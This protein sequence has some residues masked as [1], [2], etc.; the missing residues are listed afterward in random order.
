[1]LPLAAEECTENHRGPDKNTFTRT[2]S[3]LEPKFPSIPICSHPDLWAPTI[4]PSLPAATPFTESS[5]EDQVCAVPAGSG[6]M[7]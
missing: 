2:C 1:M 3:H 4:L 7:Q 5:D 6:G